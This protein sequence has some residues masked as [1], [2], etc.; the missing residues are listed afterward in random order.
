MYRIRFLLFKFIHTYF[1][2]IPSES[3]FIVFTPYFIQHLIL[4]RYGVGQICPTVANGTSLVIVFVMF[5]V[6]TAANM[7]LTEGDSF[8]AVTSSSL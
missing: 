3:P 7:K 4:S 6:L 8:L 2:H 5:L 1:V